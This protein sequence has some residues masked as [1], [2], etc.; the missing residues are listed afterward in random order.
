[1]HDQAVCCSNSDYSTAEELCAFQ[2]YKLRVSV[3]SSSR[4]PKWALGVEKRTICSSP[5]C[6]MA[7]S[8]QFFRGKRSSKA[9]KENITLEV[10]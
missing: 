5:A 4:Q 3:Y 6:E 1:M 10:R 7:G 2:I 9:P 8:A